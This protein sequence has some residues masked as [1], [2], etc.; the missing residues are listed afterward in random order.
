MKCFLLQIY[1]QLSEVAR[2]RRLFFAKSGHGGHFAAAAAG[3]CTIFRKL[4]ALK[5]LYF[6]FK[7]YFCIR[8]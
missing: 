3:F 5:P 1:A 4:F 2:P 6:K 8:F 7:L